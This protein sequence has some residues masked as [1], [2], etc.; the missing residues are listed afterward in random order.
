MDQQSLDALALRVTRLLFVPLEASGRHVHLTQEQSK[1]LFGHR[2][3]P[4]RPLSQPGQFLANERVTLIGQKG[5]F[6][7]VAVLGPERKDAQVEI[8]LTDGR[9]LGLTPPIRMSGDAKHSPGI[10]LKGALGS[11]TLA[12]GVIAAQRHIHL[13]PEEAAHF[14]VT[15]G[16]VV[17]IQTFT[18]RPVI[19]QDVIVRVHPQFRAAVHLDYDEANACGMTAHSLGRILA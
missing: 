19:F 18:E 15:D 9:T 1:E 17:S 7:N 14:G 11:L 4:K 5:E 13:S 2:L 10:T 6:S 12:E 16:Q 8:S 3:T